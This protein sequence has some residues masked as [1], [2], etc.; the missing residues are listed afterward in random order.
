[1]VAKA[2]EELL[3]DRIEDTIPNS[4]RGSNGED[5]HRGAGLEVDS[6]E[7][8]RTKI[9]KLGQVISECREAEVVTCGRGEGRNQDRVL[10]DN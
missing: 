3:I 2:S 7:Q 4:C 9:T 1:M 8:K 10:N 6:S 5:M